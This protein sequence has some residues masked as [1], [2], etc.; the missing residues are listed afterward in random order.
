MQL[1]TS[2][3]IASAA[4]ASATA[5][6]HD[7]NSPHLARLQRRQSNQDAAS[8][9]KET[10][11]KQECAAAYQ[12]PLEGLKG[13]KLPEPQKIAE[14]IDGDDEAKKVWQEIQDSGI[15]PKDVKQKKDTTSCLLYTSPSP[16]DRG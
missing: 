2:L 8:V 14:I 12:N 9:A 1:T 6:L 13:K 3:I 7:V 4:F 15:I 16:R 11:P 5:S 10:D